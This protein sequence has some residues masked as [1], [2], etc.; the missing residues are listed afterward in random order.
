MNR[1]LW[2]KITFGNNLITICSQFGDGIMSRNP[3]TKINFSQGDNDGDGIGNECDRDS[4]NDGVF[5]SHNQDK[6]STVRYFFTNTTQTKNVYFKF[7][8]LHISIQRESNRVIQEYQLCLDNLECDMKKVA[9]LLCKIRKQI[10]K[11]IISVWLFLKFIF[12][13]YRGIQQVSCG[14]CL[15]IWDLSSQ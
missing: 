13:G 15:F 4:D 1:N 11:K 8:W 5:L 12:S 6:C 14:D 2:N 10:I 3:W 7:W 9:W